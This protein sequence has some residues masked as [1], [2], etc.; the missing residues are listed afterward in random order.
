MTAK[1]KLKWGRFEDPRD[2]KTCAR[3]EYKMDEASFVCDRVQTN[4]TSAY[5]SGTRAQ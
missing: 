5:I 2:H 4:Y 3:L 1:A